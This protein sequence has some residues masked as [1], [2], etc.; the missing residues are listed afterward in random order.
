[1]GQTEINNMKVAQ[2]VPP[3]EFVMPQAMDAV[4]SVVLRD[5]KE[6]VGL[7]QRS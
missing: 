6:I 5:V 2:V 1:M 7:V 3:R 4:R